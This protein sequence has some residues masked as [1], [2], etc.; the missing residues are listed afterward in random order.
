MRGTGSTADEQKSARGDA[1]AP[2]P[3]NAAL[4]EP[5][6]PD[7]AEESLAARS[8]EDHRVGRAGM[9]RRRRIENE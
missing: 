9:P 1:P 6:E 2:A 4:P 3:R 5:D 8:P 7:I